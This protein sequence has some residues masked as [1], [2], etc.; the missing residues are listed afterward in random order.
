[1]RVP[2]NSDNWFGQ[3]EGCHARRTA[4]WV[5]PL[6]MKVRV[7]HIAGGMLVWS[8]VCTVF[9]SSPATY[10]DERSESALCRHSLAP[11]RR[12]PSL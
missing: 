6:V 3:G 1:M 9:N 10:L 2:T 4:D 11:R 5:D 12:T 7:R 8:K